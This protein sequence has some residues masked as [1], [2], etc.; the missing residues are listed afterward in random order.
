M[1]NDN[2]VANT[3]PPGQTGNQKRFYFLQSFIPYLQ[4]K[5][6]RI[7]ILSIIS[8]AVGFEDSAL[9]KV[10]LEHISPTDQPS[11]SIIDYLLL[12]LKIP[13]TDPTKWS[14]FVVVPTSDNYTLFLTSDS[15]PYPIILDGAYTGWTQVQEDPE[16][17][18]STKAVALNSANLYTLTLNSID[19]STLF[20]KS[21]FAKTA[22]PSSASLPD[23]A[24]Q[25]TYKVFEQLQKIAI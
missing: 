7:L 12:T 18:W 2:D 8:S 14:G 23:F 22:I 4:Q 25:E 3:D 9:A 21:S 19:P 16:R 5:L 24:H 6:A 20:W 1:Q 17:V 11:E 15:T 10:V 13:N